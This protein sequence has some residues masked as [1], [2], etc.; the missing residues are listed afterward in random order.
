MCLRKNRTRL[1]ARGE[2]IHLIWS[3]LAPH[4]YRYGQWGPGECLPPL[5]FWVSCFPASLGVR[6]PRDTSQG[7]GRSDGQAWHLNPCPVVA[8][9]ELCWKSWGVEERSIWA[10]KGQGAAKWTCTTA[11]EKL[12]YYCSISQNILIQCSA[13]NCLGY[14]RLIM[15][16]KRKVHFLQVTSQNT[17]MR[18]SSL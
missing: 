11:L 1:G 17:W 3:Q 8:S 13:P 18:K 2:R 15:L 16:D 9:G 6:P 14:S 7:A 4:A 5:S 12:S 10:Q